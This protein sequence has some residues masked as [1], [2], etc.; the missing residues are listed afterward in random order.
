M[1]RSGSD[2]AVIA[3]N[4]ILLECL[5]LLLKYHSCSALDHIGRTVH[6][7]VISLP[8]SD[9]TFLICTAA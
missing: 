8:K 3:E 1:Q 4:L 2:E 9:T 7:Q 5:H 6:T